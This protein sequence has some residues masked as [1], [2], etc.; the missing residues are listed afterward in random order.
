MSRSVFIALIL[1]I[2]AAATAFR[3][4]ELSAR[5]M[6]GDEAVNAF[7]L[8]ETIEGRGYKYDPHEYHG[9]TLNYLSLASAL[10]GGV[11][12]HAGLNEFILRSVPVI[13]GTML[14]LLLLHICNT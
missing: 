14:L 5:P 7:K 12:R 1:L 2:A 4:S 3:L 11:D 10:L 6:H 9:P 8:G 13:F